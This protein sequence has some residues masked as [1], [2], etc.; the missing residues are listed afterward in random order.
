MVMICQI[1][2]QRSA[3]V[4]MKVVLNGKETQLQLCQTCFQSQKQKIASNFGA[5][6]NP[7]NGFSQLPI[8]DLFKHIQQQ[9]NNDH[10]PIQQ[11]NQNHSPSNG[12]LDQFGR[13]LNQMA[14]A[15]LI[16]PV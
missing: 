7:F 5:S 8:D 11:L 15:G 12:F 1:C 10:D 4:N 14:K 6:F 16:D 13:N 2:Q 9:P 3:N